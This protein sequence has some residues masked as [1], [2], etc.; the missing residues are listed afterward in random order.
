MPWE[1]P[2]RA[3][4]TR[5]ID[6]LAALLP[7]AGEAA[8]V[9]RLPGGDAYYAA[10]LKLHTTTHLAPDEIHRT[11]LEQVADLKARIGTLLEA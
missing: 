1:G 9:G 10:V 5:Q 3:A 8:G 11:G 7:R 4:L 6:T 2:I